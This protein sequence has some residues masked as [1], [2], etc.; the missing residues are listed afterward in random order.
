MTV[1][2]D[3]DPA[4]LRS[5]GIVGGGQLAL[6]LAEAAAPLEVAVHVQTPHPDDPATRRAASV[7]EA[8][9][10]AVQATRELAERC[11]AISFEN[12][13]IPIEDLSVLAEE[14]VRFLPGLEALRPLIDKRSQRQL[15][16]ALHL[17]TLR[18]CPLEAVLPHPDDP[19]DSEAAAEPADAQGQ[20]TG[21]HD[22]SGRQPNGM[23]LAAPPVPRL[24]QG[25]RFPVMAKAASGGYD[26]KGTRVLRH[27]AE[28][29][30]LL[31]EV[32]PEAWLLE[33]LVRFDLELALVAC[34]DRGGA[35][36][37]FPLVQTHQ[38]RQ[39]CDWVLAPAPVDHGVGAFARN[40]AASLL[41]ALDYVGVLAIE[42][43]YG[44]AGLQIN[45][46]APRTH[47]SGHYTIEAC[48]TSQFEQQV[49]IVTGQPMGD[50]AL[51]V[52]GALMLNLLGQSN[53]PTAAE[54]QERLQ[55]LQALPGAHLHW[56]GK[57]EERSGRK[58]G[59]LTLLL[60]GET[61]E[62][63]QQEAQERIE[64]VR[65]LWPLPDPSRSS[66]AQ[67]PGAV[68]AGPAAE[69]PEP[70]P[71]QPAAATAR[72][73]EPATAQ[74]GKAAAAG[75]PAP[76]SPAAEALQAEAAADPGTPAAKGSSVATPEPQAPTSERQ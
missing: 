7:V 20:P 38:H 15:L 22:R 69:V 52:P 9:L 18:W 58:L 4:P 25:F 73:P 1:S 40:V 10:Q 41:T 60:Q 47:N 72:A 28:L 74:P 70:G 61:Q 36:Q 64:Q 2:A 57:S 53:A 49:R 42:F 32:E 29:E 14:G 13:W 50:P 55:S 65:Q 71:A 21:T 31:E 76:G 16:D 6:M 39:V 56:Y 59:H 33:E 54:Q 12:E 48:R 67:R 44:P 43:F 23:P 62:A 37:L 19:Q 34:R 26:G 11:G 30:A 68:P 8:P 27:Q 45:E 75:I 46:I 63:R 5:I 66:D 35:V 51:K 3:P 24:P 17:P